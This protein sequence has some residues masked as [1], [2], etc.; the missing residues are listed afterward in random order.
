MED[1]KIIEFASASDASSAG[2]YYKL[3]RKREKK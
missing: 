1:P 2:K 3:K